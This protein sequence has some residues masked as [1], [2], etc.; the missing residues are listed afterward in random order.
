MED[1]LSEFE[2]CDEIPTKLKKVIKILYVFECFKGYSVLIITI[3]DKVFG[4][5][6]NDC[7][8]CGLG[9]EIVVKEQQIIEE[10]C[11]K[12]VIQFYNGMRFVLALTSDNKLYGWGGNNWG[13]L[14][15]PF[16]NINRIYKPFLIN[17][18][19]DVN[20]KQISCGAFHTLLLS[21]DGL[22]FGWGDNK[23]GQ[24]GCGQNDTNELITQLK[25]LPKI[26]SIHCSM[27]MS[28]AVTDNGFVYSWG[29]NKNHCLGYE[30][31][32]CDFVFIP[33]MID[34]L[35]DISS[36][37][38]TED[39]TYFLSNYGSI[40]F[41]GQYYFDNKVCYQISPILMNS[42]TF[43]SIQSQ[44]LF[45]QSK[46][47]VLAIKDQDIYKIHSN[48]LFQTQY[49]SVDEL[50][51]KEYHIT[52]RT[53]HIYINSSLERANEITA[54]YMD[55]TVTVNNEFLKNFTICNNINMNNFSI[56]LLQV[57]DDENGYNVLFVT[58]DDN[59]F[60]FGSNQ[61]GCCGLGHNK[62]VKDPQIIRE[63][64]DK[65]VQNFYIGLH[66]V[67]AITSK[68]KLYGL[69]DN[70]C[71]QLARK[72]N[73][74][75]NKPILIGGLDGI[76][77]KQISCGSLHALLLTNDG[78][79]YGWGDNSLGQ[80][81]CGRDKGQRIECITRL[82]TVPK[83]KTILCGFAWSFAV[84]IDS[85]VYSWGR[86]NKGQ[87]GQDVSMELIYEPRIIINL[88]DIKSI[89]S[90]NNN[91]YFLSSDGIIYF[92][93]KYFEQNNV[94]SHQRIPII[95]KS[96]VKYNLLYST[97][98][99]QKCCPIGCALTDDSV[100]ALH[101]NR[102]EKTSYKTLEEYYSKECQ[103]TYKTYLLRLQ[104]QISENNITI[105]GIYSCSK[106]KS[107]SSK[108]NC[109]HEPSF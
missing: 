78:L 80:I 25:G 87:L 54:R 109:D 62:F 72:C 64:C 42:I 92:C 77:I 105:K 2:I 28:F 35:S 90:S 88:T 43:S 15:R 55:Q 20:I 22:V 56:K 34:N 94:K 69:G 33:K 44:I 93:G 45:Y 79:V 7:G 21:T 16:T 76:N 95:L 37:C 27:N 81:G 8:V 36:V 30:L 31:V 84:T 12:S 83:I 57:F 108:M 4:F 70:S 99:Y 13:Q 104:S 85:L 1:Y 39:N 6:N 107:E 53:S 48:K 17:E 51:S 97:Y 100:F 14:A 19:T 52:F 5:G 59:V 75:V 65:L 49:K 38:C 91:T 23:Y 98:Y 41:C 9:H 24:I 96:D 66:F 106:L 18:L 58:Y 74:E 89:C 61:F 102:I 103:L 11:D 47:I 86:N 63:L 26:K 46:I 67:L 73:Q 82:T 40:Y 10:L 71:G 3:D 68:N 60:G 50:F 101:Y 32:S 29:H